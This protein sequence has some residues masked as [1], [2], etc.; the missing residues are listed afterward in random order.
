MVPE[1]GIGTRRS[2]YRLICLALFFRF[3]P[4]QKMRALAAQVLN[5][6]HPAKYLA[7][8][9][10][11]PGAENS[12]VEPRRFADCWCLSLLMIN[13]NDLITATIGRNE[14]QPISRRKVAVLLDNNS[15]YP[16]SFGTTAA[17]VCN[18]GV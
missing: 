11:C 10:T 12:H 7:P 6:D 17:D 18:C 13:K 3:L 9:R 15:I 8:P 16:S 4:F 2:Q 1:E 5:C 14:A